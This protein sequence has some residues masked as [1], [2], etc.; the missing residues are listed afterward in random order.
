MNVIL[1]YVIISLAALVCITL[2]GFTKAY[3][4][5]KLGD[6]AI[7][8][9]GKVSLNPKKHFEIIGFIMF[10]V[11][12]Y[13]WTAPIDTSALY[14]KD[15]KKGNILVSIMPFIVALIC[16]FLSFFIFK[17][18]VEVAHISP[19]NFISVFFNNL[20]VF[21]INFLVF[22]ILPVYPLFGQKLFQTILPANKAIKLSQYEKLLQVLI[23]FLLL[24][25]ILNEILNIVSISIFKVMASLLRFSLEGM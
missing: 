21:F 10:V 15:R 12:G 6:I 20:I 24:S 25:G 13:G 1:Q 3:T 19:L 11:F 4:S 14:Y 5:Y 22:N 8:N 23:M 7:K 2:M 16:S 17:V 9:M 18:L